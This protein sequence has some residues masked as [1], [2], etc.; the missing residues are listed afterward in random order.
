M[1]SE[2]IYFSDHFYPE[3]IYYADNNYLKREGKHSDVAKRGSRRF[4]RIV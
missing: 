2:I 3:I 1:K 4:P